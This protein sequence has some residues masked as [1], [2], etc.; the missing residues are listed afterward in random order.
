MNALSWDKA[1]HLWK[2]AMQDGVLDRGTHWERVLIRHVEP[3][4]LV[5]VNKVPIIPL[6]NLS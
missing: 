1:S 5:L 6:C 2:P 4:S 3:R